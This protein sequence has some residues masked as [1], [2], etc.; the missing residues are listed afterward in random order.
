MKTLW[1]ACL[2]TALAVAGERTPKNKSQSALDVFIQE[3]ETGSEP[4]MAPAPGTI[5]SQSAVLGD[6]ARD[7]RAQFVNDIV[8]IRVAERA[9]AVASGDVKSSR[10]SS[11]DA[12]ISGIPGVTSSK[13]FMG[14]LGAS[15]SVDLDGTA[16]TQRQTVVSTTLAARVTHALPN[17]LLVVQAVK[18]VQVNS[19]RQV[20][21]VRGVARPIDI[22]PDN[23][24]STDRL[25][26]LEVLVNGKGIVGDAVRRPNFLYRLLI[27][28]L[29][30]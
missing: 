6:A 8:L 18:E 13:P 16:S 26:H 30:F 15:K 7:V 5:W 2:M 29:P 20:V 27:G 17:G 21:T 22:N 10:Q 4:G 1:V 3:A 23:S 11:V 24:I 9:S 14:P 12:S 25:A 19:E 28:L